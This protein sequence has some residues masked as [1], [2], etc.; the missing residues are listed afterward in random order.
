MTNET[1]VES[2]DGLFGE[3]V[4]FANGRL[5]GESWPGVVPYSMEHYDAQ[6]N[7]IGSSLSLGEGSWRHYDRDGLCGVTE[8]LPCGSGTAANGTCGDSVDVFGGSVSFF[9]AD[10]FA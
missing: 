3:K 1:I 7:W 8:P 4:H 10:P 6:G 2:W 9:D 5:A